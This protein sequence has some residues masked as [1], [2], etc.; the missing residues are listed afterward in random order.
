MLLKRVHSEFYLFNIY[1]I[2]I[3][4]VEDA[5]PFLLNRR[6]G[7]IRVRTKNLAMRQCVE[8]TVSWTSGVRLLRR[9]RTRTHSEKA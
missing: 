2:V 8:T 9:A 1:S 5:V 3:Y 7:G 4:L 6:A